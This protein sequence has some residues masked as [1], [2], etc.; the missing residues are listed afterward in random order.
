M[1]F[2]LFRNCCSRRFY[3]LLFY[4]LPLTMIAAAN[5]CIVGNVDRRLAATCQG[6]PATLCHSAPASKNP[7]SD[8]PSEPARPPRPRKFSL[9]G[10][11]TR[12]S[13]QGNLA[14]DLTTD[15]DV[16]SSCPAADRPISQAQ[17][18]GSAEIDQVPARTKP[19]ERRRS[20]TQTWS[21]AD[22]SMSISMAR[23]SLRFTQ[24]GELV[25]E[26]TGV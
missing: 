21:I 3:P 16:L 5:C 22:L 12:G 19:A 15:P 26:M 23:G 17:E 8:A 4:Q 14:S 7:S 11:L 10:F 20:E 2:P 25:V 24:A 13:S 1:F 18:Q 9:M 6:L